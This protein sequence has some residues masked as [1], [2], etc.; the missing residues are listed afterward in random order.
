VF[1][2][3]D[4]S[5][6]PLASLIIFALLGIFAGVLGVA[7]NKGLLKTMD[8]FARLRGYWVLGIT[9]V[10]GAI[11]GLISWFSPIVVGETDTHSQDWFWRENF[12][13]QLSRSFLQYGFL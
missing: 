2:I 4:Y 1:E 11:I 12:L 9:A 6:P 5:T 13:W 10:V 3:P 8:L 7:F